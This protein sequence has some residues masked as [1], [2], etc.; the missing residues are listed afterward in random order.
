MGY[1]EKRKIA[2][3]QKG[4]AMNEPKKI[5]FVFKRSS[6]YKLLPVNGAW[7]G[8]TPRG[9]FILEFFVEHNT[10]PNYVTNEITPEGKLGDEVEKDPKEPEGIIS[11]T[12][13]LVGGILVSIEHAKSLANFILEKCSEFEKEKK[14]REEERE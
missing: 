6:D 11:V 2:H 5:K 9:D 13:E 14:K 8:L 4:I 10:T 7:G 3:Y 12:R 1:L